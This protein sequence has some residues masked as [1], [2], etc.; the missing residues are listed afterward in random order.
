MT[1]NILEI[2]NLSVFYGPVQALRGVSL[3]VPQG[4]I[5]CLIGA[6]GAGKTTVLHTVSGLLKPSQG[7]LKFKGDSILGSPPHELVG[8]GLVQCPEGRGVFPEMTVEENLLLGSY[9][10]RDLKDL[11]KDKDHVFELFPR[12]RERLRQMA[13]TLSG[14]E[15]QMLAIGRA[16]MAAPSLLLLDE[17]SLG[18]APQLVAAIFQTLKRINAQG[19]SI[20]LVEQ[21]AHM[22]LEVSDWAYVLETGHVILHGPANKIARDPKVRAAYLGENIT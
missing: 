1:K 7:E 4:G 2:H 6:N 16:L 22:A 9:S 15:Q 20:L 18:L 13:G 5:T 17:P 11:K 8:R 10:R 3:H 12:L 14:G 19:V 21:N